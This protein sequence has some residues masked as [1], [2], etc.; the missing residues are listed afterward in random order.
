[1]MNRLLIMRFS[2]MG[3]VAMTVP[4][5]FSLAQQ[6]PQLQITMLTNKRLLPFFEWMPANVEAI[7][8]DIKSY[9]GLKGLER[10]FHDANVHDF[11]AVADIHDVIR[12]KYVRMRFH[13]KGKRVAVIDKGRKEKKALLG[14]SADHAPLKPM[15]ERYREVFQK[16]GLDFQFTFDCLNPSAESMD[17]PVKGEKGKIIGVAPFAAHQGKVY[18]LDR[19]KR[20]VDL[21]ADDGYQVYLFGAGKDEK[22]VLESWERDGVESVSGKLGGL[23]SEL[24]LM[25]RL[26]I[27]LSMDS[28]NMHMAAMMG[29]KTLSIW[30]AT[31]PKAGFKAWQQTDDSI[32]QR[33]CN[34]R[35]CSIYGNKP[36]RMGN[37]MCMDINPETIVRAIRNGRVD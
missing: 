9:K 14:H 20:V 30:G 21:L 19:M 13:M 26:D 17:F 32:I 5:V 1:M 27:M 6:Y 18:P 7:G 22:A 16:L 29:T 15:T 31:H 34:C 25:S 12:T 11:D 37:F 28:S 10:L 2:A 23:K 36:C 24:I 3:D 33:E 35:P 8:V 4:V